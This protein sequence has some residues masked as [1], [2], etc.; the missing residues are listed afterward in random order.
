MTRLRVLAAVIAMVLIVGLV[1]TVAQAQ[2][3]RHT[4]KLIYWPSNNNLTSPSG[5]GNWN[6]GLFGLDYRLEVPSPWGAHVQYLTGGQSSWGGFFSTVTSGTDTIWSADAT[7]RW[8]TPTGIVR[9]FVGYG[10]YRG[11]FNSVPLGNPVFTSNGVRL[12]AEA[13]FPLRAN[14]AVNGSLAW[15]PS[16]STSIATASASDSATDWSIGLQYTMPTPDKWTVEGGY[17]VATVRSGILPTTFC[18][19]SPCTFQWTGFFITAG[20]TFP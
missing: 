4:F 11:Q 17:R 14:W 13:T 1:P 2:L 8:P 9:G 15:S 6:A 18:S 10:S 12:G 5:P 7:Y 16:N 3:L 20:R 19:P